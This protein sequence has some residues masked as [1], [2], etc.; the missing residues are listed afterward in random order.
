MEKV[1][2]VLLLLDVKNTQENS[3]AL[4]AV[5]DVLNFDP[6]FLS[7][8]LQILHTLADAGT[9]GLI[10]IIV[11]L[12]EVILYRVQKILQLLEAIHR[13]SPFLQTYY[14]LTRHRTVYSAYSGENYT[15]K[16]IIDNL[17]HSFRKR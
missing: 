14:F 16:R 5:F 10:V 15:Q 8:V 4:F 3:L 1:L 9:G 12:A 7:Q 2:G 6:N 13:E 17:G 11:K